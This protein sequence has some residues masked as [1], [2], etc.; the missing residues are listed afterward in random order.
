MEQRSPFQPTERRSRCIL[1][2]ARTFFL[3]LLVLAGFGTLFAASV[4]G[5]ASVADEGTFRGNR[6]EISVTL[7]ESE[8]GAT[9]TSSGTIK[10]YMNGRLIAQAATSN[11]KASFVVGAGAGTYTLAATA[12]GYKPAQKDVSLSMALDDQ[13]EIFLTRDSAANETAGVPGKPILAPKAKEEVDKAVKAL[14]DNKLDEAEKDLDEAAKLAP[15]HPDVLYLQGVV[16]LKRGNFAKAQASLETVTQLDPNNAPALTALG[17]AY[18]DQGKYQQAVPVLQHSLG[19]E[20]G[21][22]EAHWTLARAYFRSAQYEDALKESQAALEASHGAEPNIELLVAQSLTA[23]G[24][25]EDAAE[26]LRS[27]VK[28]HPSDPGADKARHWLDRLAA[29]GKIKSK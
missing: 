4:Q 27:F 2:A 24:R 22:W 29:D 16:Y 17:M 13:E 23:V 10:V 1:P 19:L 5:Q 20:S 11:G 25:Y 18:L 7:R 15:N 26:T 14:T 6:A 3:S 8:G 9:I 28:N 12:T 21:A